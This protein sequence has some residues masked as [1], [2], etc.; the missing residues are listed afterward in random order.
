M[1]QPALENPSKTSH[2]LEAPFGQETLARFWFKQ[3][4]SK[5]GV[6]VHSNDGETVAEEK[7][8]CLLKLSIRL[9]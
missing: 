9:I 6:R 4:H 3:L 2:A 8:V 5:L 7:N 1:M